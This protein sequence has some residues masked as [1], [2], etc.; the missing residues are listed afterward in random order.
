LSSIDAE[1]KSGSRTTSYAIA[2]ETCLLRQTE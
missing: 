2:V 1:L